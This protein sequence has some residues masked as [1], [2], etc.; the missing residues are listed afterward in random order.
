MCH[1]CWTGE[2]NT[3][4]IDTPAVRAIAP[5]AQRVYEFSCVGGNLHV[6]LDDWNLEDHNLE[7]CQGQLDRRGQPDPEWAARVRWK[8]TPDDPPEQLAAEQACLDALKGLTLPERASALAYFEGFWTE[9]T[10]DTL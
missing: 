10:E 5:L 9:D 2:Y 4:R 8:P 7:F 1:G 6:V 3:P